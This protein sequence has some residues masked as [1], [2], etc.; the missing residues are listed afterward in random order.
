MAHSGQGLTCSPMMAPADQHEPCVLLVPRQPEHAAA[1]QF[2]VQV[3][4]DHGAG[5]ATQQDD[6]R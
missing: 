1:K 6:F 4:G 2:G 5:Q 3:G